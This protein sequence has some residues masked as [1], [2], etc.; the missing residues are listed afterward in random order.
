[1][2]VLPILADE[3]KYDLIRSLYSADTFTHF[4]FSIGVGFVKFH[5]TI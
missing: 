1:M 2:Q 3:E 5:M 4:R